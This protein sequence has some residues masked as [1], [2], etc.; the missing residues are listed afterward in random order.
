MPPTTVIETPEALGQA[1]RAHRKARGMS[2]QTTAPLAEVGVRFLSEFERGKPTAELG[3]V[4]DSL[5]ATG[6][7][8]AVVERTGEASASTPQGGYS[9]AVGTEFPYD[10]SNQHMESQV[11]ILSVLNA[12]RFNDVLKTV[13]YFGFEQVSQALPRLEDEVLIG[14]TASMLARIYKGWLLA[15]CEQ[16]NHATP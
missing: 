3:K 7:D 11:F 1:A 4:M 8:L 13:A 15:Q 14:K 16:H 6:L 2:L 9:K 5:H 12:G 10:W